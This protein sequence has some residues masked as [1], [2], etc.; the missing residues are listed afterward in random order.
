MSQALH[1]EALSNWVEGHLRDLEGSY[2][3]FTDQGS[4][5]RS[6]PGL[7]A[8]ASPRCG[9]SPPHLPLYPPPPLESKEED[10]AA[11]PVYDWEGDSHPQFERDL[12]V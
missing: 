4:K 6:R 10:R 5:P 3:C 11:P 7:A 9:G 12:Q 1:H 2:F 8:L